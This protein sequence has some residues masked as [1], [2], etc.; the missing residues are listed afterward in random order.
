[1]NNKIKILIGDDS[2]EFGVCYASALRE[3][4][5]YVIT[6]SKDGRVLFDAIRNEQPDVVICD[7]VLPNLDAIELLKRIN[8]SDMKKPLMIITSN[9]DNPFVEKAVMANGAAY[10]LLRPFDIDVL[11]ER[12]KE[13]MGVSVVSGNSSNNYTNN[14]AF[15][16]EIVVTD[17]IHQI[18]VP[19]HI[20]GYHYLREA[21]ILS[22]F[23]YEMLESVTKQLYPAVAKKFQTTA[24]RVER[25][26]R[27]G[28]ETAW[29]RG[30]VN[31]INSIFGC[32]IDINKGKPTN[33]EFIA[34]VTDKIRLNYKKEI[35]SVV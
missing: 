22:I 3:K 20:K 10:F 17:M 5:F 16:L 35:E 19:A 18:G 14:N 15:N 34:M 28:I 25:A 30:N 31:T 8:A 7:A 12:I 13:L 4:D 11:A 29:D 33:S 32:T 24:S 1:M 26:I 6:R 2:V 23:D 9:Y 27:H 21:I